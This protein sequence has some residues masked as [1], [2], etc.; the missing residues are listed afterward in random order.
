MKEN[1]E[2]RTTLNEREELKRRAAKN[3]NFLNHARLFYRAQKEI[4]TSQ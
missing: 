4:I 1:E 3:R 2:I